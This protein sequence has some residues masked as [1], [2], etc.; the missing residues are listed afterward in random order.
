MTRADWLAVEAELR[1][2]RPGWWERVCRWVPEL[3]ALEGV[4][5]PPEHHPEGDVAEHTRLAVEAVP[6]GA[7]RAVLWAVLLHDLG[8]AGAT[9]V[10]G[11][12]IT[13]H[14]H[15]ERGEALA[16][17]VLDRLAAPRDLRETVP[18]LVRHH[19]FH[20]SWNLAD[21]GRASRRQRRFA[22]DPR[23]GLLLQVVEA[24]QAA[25]LGAGDPERMR[26]YRMLWERVGQEPEEG[27]MGRAMIISVG[28]SPEPVVKTLEAH[29]P[30][31]VCFYC[32]ETTVE[33]VGQIKALAREK[34]VSFGNRNVMVTDPEDLAAC[35][36][37]ALEACERVEAAGYDADAVVVDYT[38]GTKTMSAAL[39]LATVN[40][41]YGFSYVG[42][43]AR[44]KEGQGVV[45][46]GHEVVRTGMMSPWRVFAVEEKRTFA[47]LFN[48]HLY[49]A[50]AEVMERALVREPSERRLLAALR[51]LARAYQHWDA[52]R[53]AEAKEFLKGAI[54]GLS[55]R[56]E[57]VPDPG[58]SQTLNG[59]NAT[60]DFLNRLQ[61]DT[62][63]FRRMSRLQVVDL[64][65][66][67][68]R[69]ARVGRADDA[70][71]RLYRALELVAQIAF[72]EAFGCPTG[73][74]D[75]D[76]LPGDLRETY[77]HKYWNP[78]VS[79]CQIPLRAAFEAL[80]AAGRPEGVRFAE[81]AGEFEKILYARNHSIL[82]HGFTPVAPDLPER[83]EALIRDAFGIRERVEF[84]E[85]LF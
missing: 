22:A 78:Q 66:N 39:V 36:R 30:E 35:Y 4:P 52:F 84:P 75:P 14:G 26:P 48:R 2:R 23:F 72:E 67:A 63:G 19:G 43:T 51:D 59:A 73:N 69:R 17:A 60:L 76:R 45:L 57:H 49:R 56:L 47:A 68:G 61:Q 9:R 20:L 29:G 54:E 18:W 5:Q 7:P 11:G 28:G 64:L 3:R 27:L 42:G 38:G 25:R 55:I 24:D 32:S 46:S 85:V 8:K 40:R 65:A 83:F 71:G 34:G 80:A 31:F 74:A 62:R 58:L 15:A 79:A 16:R 33:N 1:E 6:A 70:V 77:R 53:H 10:R 21:P 44:D 41:G 13:A 50:A 37:G 82:A 81:R 12:R